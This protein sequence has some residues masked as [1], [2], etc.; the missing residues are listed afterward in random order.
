[1]LNKAT[2][3]FHAWK[4]FCI[5]LKLWDLELK[6]DVKTGFDTKYQKHTTFPKGTIVVQSHANEILW[7]INLSNGLTPGGH[8]INKI[9]HPDWFKIVL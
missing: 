6:K 2:Q 1:M 7:L 8:V 9:L 5:M 3:P 4:R